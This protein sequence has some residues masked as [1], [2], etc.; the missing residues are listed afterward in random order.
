MQFIAR[1]ALSQLEADEKESIKQSIDDG[2]RLALYFLQPFVERC[3]VSKGL[4]AAGNKLLAIEVDT[5]ITCPLFIQFPTEAT[6]YD[7]A[8]AAGDEKRQAWD[9]SLRPDFTGITNGV[10][11]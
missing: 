2:L 9:A 1:V 3:E 4:A 11:H 6:F 10:G 8:A 5:K 7:K